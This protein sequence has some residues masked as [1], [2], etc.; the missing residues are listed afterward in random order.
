MTCSHSRMSPPSPAR[1][2]K[3]GG[4]YAYACNLVDPSNQRA[5]HSWP[6]IN[7]IAVCPAAYQH[8]LH[9]ADNPPICSEPELAWPALR[10]SGGER[11]MM[12]PLRWWVVKV[13]KM[14]FLD[15]FI[16]EK[17]SD[18]TPF[19]QQFSFNKTSRSR[20]IT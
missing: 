5:G 12:Q 10:K 7:R 3:N 11:G 9:P 16:R 2:S 6:F 15:I 19:H 13:N 1:Q 18:I 14:L 4:E 8:A 17:S 20:R